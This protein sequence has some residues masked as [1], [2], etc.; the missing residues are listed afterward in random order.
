MLV[1]MSIFCTVIMVLVI[2][3]F[4]NK[5]PVSPS[6]NRT[7][8]NDIPQDSMCDQFKYLSHHRDYLL[9]STASS[10]GI[11]YFYVFT[12]LIGEIIL[13]F[14]IDDS[15]FFGTL[16]LLFNIFGILGGICTAL[17]LSKYPGLFKQCGILIAVMTLLTLCLF[18]YATY[19]V[20]RGFIKVAVAMNG[21]CN[22]A[23]WA[24]AYE[25]AVYQTEPHVGEAMSCSIINM[26]ANGISI[27]L[28]FLFQLLLK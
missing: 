20:D 5:P 22:L 23:I 21:F 2:F 8:L 17:V 11:V 13:P 16:G 7:S 10:I 12:T 15:A 14:G 26:A 27:L 25:M 9:A 24:M 18:T 1:V 19:I 4:Q 3:T 28:V 6:A